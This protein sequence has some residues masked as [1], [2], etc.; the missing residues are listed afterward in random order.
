MPYWFIWTGAVKVTTEPPSW[1]A[2]VCVLSLFTSELG[3]NPE[4]ETGMLLGLN[5]S[6]AVL[7]TEAWRSLKSFT[8]SEEDDMMS[9]MDT[10]L[11]TA[12][13][14]VLG[15]FKVTGCEAPTLSPLRMTP[16]GP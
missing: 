14:V 9:V 16:L 2:T 6:A 8:S 3:I 13:E 5:V 10:P 12:L 15:E 7:G 4:K 1:E 11:L